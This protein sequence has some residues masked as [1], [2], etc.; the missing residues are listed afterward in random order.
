MTTITKERRDEIRAEMQDLLAGM[1]Q[2]PPLAGGPGAVSATYTSLSFAD[3][4]ALLDALDAAEKAG[5]WR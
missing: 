1:D 3:V 2:H 5:R 4:L